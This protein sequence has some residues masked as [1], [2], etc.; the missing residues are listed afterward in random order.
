MGLDSALS[1][2]SGGLANINAQLALVSQNVANAAT[3]AYAVETSTQQEITANGIGLGVHT[4]PATRQINLALQASVVQQNATVSGLTTT[5]TAL[6]AID[7][8]LGTPG[9]GSDLG[10]LLAVVQNQFSTLLT[11][12][13]SQA[14]QSAV[15]S[16]ASDLATGINNLSSAYTT[17]RQAAQDDLGSAVTTLNAT[18]TTIGQ[19]SDQ[20]VAMQPSG[21][22][23][24]DLENQRDAAVQTLSSL[25]DI[26][27]IEQPNGDLSVF[28]PGGLSLPTRGVTNPFSIA[29]GSAQPGAYYPGG[30]LPGIMA[31]GNNV[32]SGM[33]GGQIGAD[34]TLRDKTLPTDQAEL[35]EFAFSMSSRFSA[36]GLNLFTDPTQNIPSGGGIPV[37]NTYVGYSA[38]VQVNPTIIA[39]PSL[40]RDGTLQN[41]GD[42][43]P[44]PAAGPGGVPP[45]G[46][47]GFADLISRVLNYTFGSQVRAGVA[48]P[49]FDTT[50]LG[51]DGTLTA[52]FSS[53]TSLSDYAS[54]MVSSQAQQSATT[55]G[56]LTTEQALQTSLTSKVAAV[57]GVSMDTE[58]SMMITLQNA[59]GVNA[60]I[61]TA[62]QS[63]FSQLL[64]AVQ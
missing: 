46:P 20:I 38:A 49:A 14:Q 53:A 2:A 56:N 54:D 18:L 32:T 11:N 36:Q 63:M 39:N 27:T 6:Q 13:S 45:A 28:T 44:N 7:A 31:S 34:L 22:S 60:R 51:A 61:M 24:A 62:V 4:G 57:S 43:T 9:Q 59:Y 29:G 30:G 16:A 17:Q 8:V 35:D 1:I 47:A 21:L 55:T 41:S 23:T 42:F 3:P 58:M 19:L 64:Q 12:P 5:Q 48:Q 40:V 37:Q 52:P 15:V 33:T 50:A 10:S 25:V 26:K